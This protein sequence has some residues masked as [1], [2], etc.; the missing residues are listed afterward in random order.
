GLMENTHIKITD[1]N[2]NLVYETTSNGS[3]ATW[4]GK[5]LHGQKVST[6]IY[7]VIGAS[8]DG[9]QSTITKILVIN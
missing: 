2:G 6:G 9:T 3:L 7:L 8:K 1:L 4:N 5:N